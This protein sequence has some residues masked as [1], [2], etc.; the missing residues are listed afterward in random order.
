MT[1]ITDLTTVGNEDLY[2]QNKLGYKDTHTKP[3]DQIES[4]DLITDSNITAS[5][6][7]ALIDLWTVNP[8]VPDTSPKPNFPPRP[9]NHQKQNAVIGDQILPQLRVT[10]GG[11]TKFC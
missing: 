5:F 9:Q 1:L 10:P 2:D 11:P 6:Q 7:Y 3:N 4:D 8:Q